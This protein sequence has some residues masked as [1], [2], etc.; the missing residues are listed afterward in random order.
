MNTPTSDSAS[1]PKDVHFLACVHGMWGNPSHLAVLQQTIKDKFADNTGETELATLVLETNSESFT[2]DGIDWCAERAVKEIYGMVEKLEKDGVKKVTKFSIVGYSLGG[3]ISRY[4]IGILYQRGFFRTVEPVNFTTFATPHLGT[5]HS[6]GFFG[7][8]AG[9]LGPTMLSR[10]GK[11]F[12]G[13]D[14]DVW[15][16]DDKEGRPLLEV[17]SDKDTVFFKALV[18]FPNMTIYGNAV[19]DITVPYCTALIEPH[20]HFATSESKTSRL[21]IKID[22]NYRHVI[23]SFYEAPEGEP[24]PPH[25]LEI[26]RRA[27]RDAIP[28]YR[29]SRYRT[30]RPWTPPFLN[31]RFPLNLVRH[32]T[33]CSTLVVLLIDF[34]RMKLFYMVT[35]VFFP[36]MLSY[37]VTRLHRESGV[38]RKRLREIEKSIMAE[39][40]LSAMLRKMEKAMAEVVD[41]SEESTLEE[42]GGAIALKEVGVKVAGDGGEDVKS[43]VASLPTP[44]PTPKPTAVEPLQSQ[45]P[46]HQ[47][48]TQT[49]P[50]STDEGPQP[51][52]TPS[53]HKMIASLNSI[54]QLKKVVVYFPWARNSHSAIV[55]RE[56]KTWDVNRDGLGILKHWA[57]RFVL[58]MS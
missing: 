31:F 24:V 46:S 34:G 1:T 58:Q 53:H 23:E 14:S 5:L 54:P 56:P 16:P 41:S 22:P 6:E 32:T 20:D 36:V 38:S 11:Q 19:Y 33:L 26:E 27:K 37:L 3:L 42:G 17:M 21:V 25:E 40:S 12:Y 51:V 47:S 4:A 48:S 15:S 43:S 2:Y 29:P 44:A 49:K 57:D 52:L 9:K 45:E 10:T 35:P 13:T 7:S 28:W 30:G 39:T 55:V 18:S 50:K 8:I